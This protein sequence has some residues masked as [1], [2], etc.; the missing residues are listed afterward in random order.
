MPNV[1]D[2]R[3]L[4]AYNQWANRRLLEAVTRL[5]AAELERALEG[6]FG[7]VRG[8]LR[9]IFWGEH[10]WLRFLQDGSLIPDLQPGDLSDLPAIQA[11]WANLE[12]EQAAFVTALTDEALGGTRFVRD[13]RYTLGELLQHILNHSTYHRGQ[14]ALLLRQLGHAPPA[15]DYRLFLTETRQ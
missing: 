14:V 10:W 8:T 2:T 1:Q 9:H 4:F 13:K 3:I 12:K 5:S 6:S 15:T 7:S 11:G